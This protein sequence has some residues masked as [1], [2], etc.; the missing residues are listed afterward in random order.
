MGRRARAAGVLIGVLALGACGD[1]GVERR[2]RCTSST[3]LL[4][5]TRANLVC[6][7][8]EG[9]HRVRVVLGC[10]PEGGEAKLLHVDAGTGVVSGLESR[11]WRW[12]GRRLGAGGARVRLDTGRTVRVEGL[13]GEERRL[14]ARHTRVCDG[15]V[16]AE[17]GNG[18]DGR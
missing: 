3:P 18:G 11:A 6:E 8:E 15:I 12:W 9:P 17:I 1:V 4:W 5:E 14:L 16:K 13:D 10:G 2:G 7:L